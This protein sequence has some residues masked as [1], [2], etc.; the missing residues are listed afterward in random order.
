MAAAFGEDGLGVRRHDCPGDEA[1]R[2]DR[3]E[4]LGSEGVLYGPCDALL[5]GV[6]RQAQ[7]HPQLVP[8]VQAQ[9]FIEERQA[10]SPALARLAQASEAPAHEALP[11]RAPVVG[12]IGGALQPP[13]L[14]GAERHGGVQHQARQCVL[15]RVCVHPHGFV[16]SGGPVLQR[17]SLAR[18]EAYD[19]RGG[20]PGQQRQQQERNAPTRCH[21]KVSGVRGAPIVR[22]DGAG[23][24]EGVVLDSR[25][26]ACM[27][28]DAPRTKSPDGSATGPASS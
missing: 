2:N 8:L 3:V 15:E 25:V 5:H 9:R 26:L 7:G 10:V 28:S 14:G 20:T 16:G 1:C 19:A 24:S 17:R 4:E 22:E 12:W 23:T 13:L 18:V 21:E 6:E 11:G 27:A